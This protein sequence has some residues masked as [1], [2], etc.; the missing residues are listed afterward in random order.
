VRTDAA[1]ARR[2]AH[3]KRVLQAHRERRATACW[4]YAKSGPHQRR[5]LRIFGVEA[6]LDDVGSR[7]R[8]SSGS[9]DVVRV[10]AGARPHHLPNRVDAAEAVEQG[11]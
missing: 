8:M 3:S 5:G 2:V 10:L 7:W 11:D 1:S 6:Q 9:S 4:P